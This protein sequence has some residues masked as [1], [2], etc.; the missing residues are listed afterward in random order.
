[1]LHSLESS[2]AWQQQQAERS[3]PQGICAAPHSRL[4]IKHALQQLA[5]GCL[6]L[7]RRRQ[8]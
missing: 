5:A 6:A 4:H 3:A 8:W 7:L 1:V 2:A